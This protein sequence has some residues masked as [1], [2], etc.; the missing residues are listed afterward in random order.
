MANEVRSEKEIRKLTRN[1][2]SKKLLDR[3]QPMKK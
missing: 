2:L 3:M 1:Y